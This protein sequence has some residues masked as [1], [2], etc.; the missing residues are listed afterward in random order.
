MAKRTIARY[1]SE[2]TKRDLLDR[3]GKPDPSHYRPH[4]LDMTVEDGECECA[5]RWCD[6]TLSGAG[7]T[8]CCQRLA[9]CSCCRPGGSGEPCKC[10]RQPEPPKPK[11]VVVEGKCSCA[12]RVCC[13]IEAGRPTCCAC[14]VTGTWV[15][16]GRP[17]LPCTNAF[18]KPKPETRDRVVE[19]H[20]YTG[21]TC[22]FYAGPVPPN[23][24]G[25]VDA[26]LII[27]E[28]VKEPTLAEAAQ[29]VVDYWDRHGLNGPLAEPLFS[30]REALR[31]ALAREKGKAK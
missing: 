26:T 19:G 6:G 28:P 31:A 7:R 1:I 5:V 11:E 22:N 10:G 14:H 23:V 29:A 15:R 20:V 3:L 2:E 27:H 9:H 17:P 21:A 8:S 25:A 16:P 24:S 30:K 4:R 13:T 12:S 18:H